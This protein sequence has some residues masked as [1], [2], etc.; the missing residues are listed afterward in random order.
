MSERKQDKAIRSG[1]RFLRA[2]RTGEH[3]GLAIVELAVVSVAL[4]SVMFG[5]IDMGR[6]VFMY[7][8]L[9]NAVRE[10]ARYGQVNP[11]ETTNIKNRVIEKSPG[12]I[13]MGYRNITVECSGGCTPDSTDV[14][15]TASYEFTAITQD[16]LG[17]GA[18]TLTSSAKADIE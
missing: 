2:L 12:L 10:G 4:F 18:I 7:S 3:S 14:K 9:N 13:G 8:E 16:L 11:G 15:V 1:P 5:A 6:A 17:I